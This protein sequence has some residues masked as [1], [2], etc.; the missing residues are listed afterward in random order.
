VLTTES[1]LLAQRSL[2]ADLRARAL[3]LSIN[4]AR[5]LGGGVV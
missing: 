1:Q 2:D 5:A 3:E 4:L